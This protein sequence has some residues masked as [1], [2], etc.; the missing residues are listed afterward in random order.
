MNIADNILQRLKEDDQSAFNELIKLFGPR[1]LNTCYK[2]LLN[3]EDAEDLSQE[4][5]IEVYQSIKKFRGESKLSTWIYRITV[6][7][8]LDEIKKRNR[9]KRINTIKRLL[10][11]DEVSSWLSGGIMPDKNIQQKDAMIQIMQA[12]NSLPDSQRV[13]FTLSKIEGYSNKEISE[14]MNITTVAVELL[15]SRAKKRTADKLEHIL[16]NDS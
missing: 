7:K 6:A 5:F 3:T 9:K 1:V 11:I 12:L 10:H 8:C 13:A 15:V 16:K 4:V 14:I 2:F